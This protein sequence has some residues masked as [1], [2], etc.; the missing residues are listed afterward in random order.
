M[1]Y[2]QERATETAFYIWFDD[3]IGLENTAIFNG[4]EYTEKHTMINEKHKFFLTSLF[5]PGTIYYDGQVFY[6]ANMKYNIFEDLLIVRL[7]K[8]RGGEETFQLHPGRV[9]GFEIEGH[10][11]VNINSQK[12][13]T[14]ITGIHEI[15]FDD[16]EIKLLKKHERRIFL[17]RD[18]SYPYHEFNDPGAAYVVFLNGEYKPIQNRR[19][20]IRAS[21]EYENLIKDH[22]KDH[23]KSQKSDP[24]NFFKGL[25]EI[26]RSHKNLK[27]Q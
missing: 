12:E 8:K 25:F 20:V 27:V 18:G 6:K 16:G 17:R 4:V 2:A 14:G 1:I 5:K 10:K 3:I 21:P 11:F 23:Q 9:Q 19:D 15:I 7:P 24:D 22:Y 13:G 26:I